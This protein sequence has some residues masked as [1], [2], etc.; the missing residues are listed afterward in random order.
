LYTIFITIEKAEQ[1]QMGSAKPPA[2]KIHSGQSG[3]GSAF[4]K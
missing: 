1:K 3:Y 4:Q 2:Q